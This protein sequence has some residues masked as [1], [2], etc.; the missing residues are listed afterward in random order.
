VNMSP[1]LK[2]HYY[3]RDDMRRA[4]QWLSDNTS[5]GDVVLTG[6]PNLAEYD[7][8]IDYFYMA[9]DDERYD[10]YACADGR[11]ERWSN[12]Q[13]LYGDESLHPL[14][15]SGRR[16]FLVMYAD[17]ASSFESRNRGRL[18]MRPVWESPFGGS[19]IMLIAGA[20]EATEL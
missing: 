20:R 8:H 18:A 13:L 14:L 19:S 16:V 2:A 3:P 17:A 6:V 15:A 7:A 5:A 1:A 4:A 10:T 11:T 12:L 9:L